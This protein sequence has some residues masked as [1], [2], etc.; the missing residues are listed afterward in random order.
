MNTC[1]TCKSWER[2]PAA[3]ECGDCTSSKLNFAWL[4]DKDSLSAFGR[5]PTTGPDFGCIHHEKTPAKKSL[6]MKLLATEK[7]HAKIAEQAQVSR[8]F[9]WQCARAT[10]QKQ[11]QAAP[12]S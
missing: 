2:A 4:P 8:Q 5:F 1:K 12:S 9:V 10:Q 3:Q 11:K 6:V 7:N